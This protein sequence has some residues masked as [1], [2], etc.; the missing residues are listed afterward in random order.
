MKNL[1][2]TILVSMV[3]F[4]PVVVAAAAIGAIPATAVLAAD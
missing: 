1:F 4:A 3:F 2:S